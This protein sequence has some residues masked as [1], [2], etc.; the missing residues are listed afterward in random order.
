VSRSR[1][2][3]RGFSLIELMVALAA[4]L[5]VAMAVMG[6]SRE[7]TNTFH[8][9]VRVSGAEM[10]LRV[11]MERIRLD[12]TRA[13]FMGTGNIAGDP[14]IARKANYVGPTPNLSNLKVG[15]LPP[16]LATLSGINLVVGGATG[17]TDVNVGAQLTD[18]GLLPDQMNIEGNFSSSDEYAAAVVWNPPGSGQCSPYAALSIQMTTPGG[19]RIRNAET[20]AAASPGYAPGQALWAAFH[21][22]ANPGSEFLVK[23]TDPSGRAQYAVTCSWGAGG[24]TYNAGG[25]PGGNLPTAMLFLDPNWTIL[26]SNDTGGVGGVLGFGVG[27]V[28]VSPLQVTRWDIASPQQVKTQAAAAAVVPSYLYSTAANGAHIDPTDFFLTRGYV[29][30]SSACLAAPCPLDPDTIEVVSEYAIDLKF[31]ISV[32]NYLNAPCI[33]TGAFPCSTA[34]PSYPTNP[35]MNY[36]MDTIPAGG[37]QYTAQVGAYSG[38]LGPQRIRDVQV[39]IGVRSPF[40]DRPLTL[41]PPPS[42]ALSPGYLFRFQIGTAG[43]SY[44]ALNFNPAYP[45]ARVREATAEVTLTNQARFFW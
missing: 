5:M 20:T 1:R 15:A 10:G 2:A 19:W 16:G 9:E 18:N 7:A 31:G 22:G 36:R 39:R 43:A 40:G 17:L 24:A 28:T 29:D 37:N 12:L 38:S 23:I 26:S 25:G 34:A 44:G 32:D 30:F 33:G 11:A 4:G 35:I 41:A 27:L 6:V 3:A 42:S 45:F 8:E 13:A 14:L 21:P